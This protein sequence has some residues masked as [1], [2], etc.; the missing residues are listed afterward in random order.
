MHLKQFKLSDKYSVYKTQYVGEYPKESFLMRTREN[1]LLY[2]NKSY[3]TENSLDIELQCKE[4]KSVDSQILH[5]LKN[6]LNQN[7]NR[8]AKSS[9]V[10][11]QV[12]EFKMHWMHTHEHLE[13]SNRT[14]LKTQWTFVYYIQIPP[15]T[16]KGEGDIIFKTEDNLEHRFTPSEGD[17]L[18]FPGE[19]PHLVMPTESAT[20]DR[21]VY[22]SNLNFDFNDKVDTHK[23]IKFEE[24]IK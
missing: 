16:I 3:K 21:V 12:P 18:I 8:V 9:W 19:L 5:F 17:I 6:K 4:F 24:I 22:A 7:I 15:N 13:S 11:I 14:R 23:R 1:E 20:M 2:F 10:Y